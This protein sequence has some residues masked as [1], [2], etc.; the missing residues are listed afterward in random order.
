MK[1]ITA[2]A[3]MAMMSNIKGATICTITTATEPKMNKRGNPLYGR[4]I[5]VAHIQMQFGYDYGKAV[6]NRLAAAG[7][8]TTF[9]PMGRSWGRWVVPNKIA[10]NKG[11][12]YLRFYTMEKSSVAEIA[13]LVDGRR[14]TA[15]EL[16]T[17]K[18]FT[19]APSASARQSE[20]GLDEHQVQPREYKVSSIV[21]IAVNGE[22]YRILKESVAVAT[23]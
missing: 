17:I 22:D 18:A 15:D 5:K 8:P 3:F 2:T 11:E 23:A 6:N 7:L 10:E 19:P 9:D 20:V 21:R 14:A 1:E 12:Y 13:Y 16:A 4:V